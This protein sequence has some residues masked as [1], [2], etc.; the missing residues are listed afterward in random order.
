[1]GR[2]RSLK[3]AAF[4]AAVVRPE[5]IMIPLEDLEL[6]PPPI[7]EDKQARGKGVQRKRLAHDGR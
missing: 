4:Q 3:A 5:A 7:A 1:M 2:L 6:V